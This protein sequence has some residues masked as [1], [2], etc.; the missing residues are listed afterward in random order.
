M[1]FAQKNGCLETAPSLGYIGDPLSYVA[2]FNQHIVN[3]TQVILTRLQ[4]AEPMPPTSLL[5]RALHTLDYSLALLEAWSGTRDLLLTMAPIMEQAGYRDEWKPYLVQ[6]LQQSQQLD[7]VATEAELGLQLG[8]LHQLRGQY[9]DAQGYLEA[10]VHQFEDLNNL[11]N[12][13]RALNQLAYLARLQ[14]DFARATALTELTRQ[15]VEPG[16]A[17]QAFNYFISGLVSLDERNW[18]EAINFSS[19]AFVI[20][21]SHTNQRMMGRSLLCRGTA[22]EKM[23]HY[24]AA[25]SV[26][27]QAV[28]LFET[29]HDPIFLA[30]AQMNLGNVYLALGTYPQALEFYAPAERIFRQAQDRTHLAMVCHNMGMVYRQLQQLDQAIKS[31]LDSIEERKKVGDVIKLANTMDGLGQVYLAQGHPKEAKTTFEA[32]LTRLATS[33]GEPGYQH[34]FDMIS[35]HLRKL[36]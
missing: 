20:W 11:S 14:R 23:A 34:L 33:A 8:I 2:V 21:Q 3:R 17:E 6:G 26:L 10:S 31:F 9:E 16:A 27:E 13:V 4:Q 5:K 12:R 15:L 1:S 30:A 22:L 36:K 29:V 35:A 18:S 25:I 28:A 24:P 7:D 19:K 32:A